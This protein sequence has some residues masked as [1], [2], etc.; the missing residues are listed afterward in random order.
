MILS[1]AIQKQLKTVVINWCIKLQRILVK[2]ATSTTFEQRGCLSCK[3][4]EELILNLNTI[5]NGYS[6]SMSISGYNFATFSRKRSRM[7]LE[8][9]N[10]LIVTM[11]TDFENSPDKFDVVYYIC[12]DL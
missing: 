5:C 1:L 12:F 6:I 8:C 4:R 3:V 10:L 9:C 11:L 2:T 7:L